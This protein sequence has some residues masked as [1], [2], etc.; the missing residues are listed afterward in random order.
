MSEEATTGEQKKILIVDDEQ[1]LR[2]AIEVTLSGLGHQVFTAENGIE[3]VEIALTEH[4][5][6]MLL[7]L[8]MPKMDGHAVLKRLRRDEAWGKK[9]NI[10]VLTALNDLETLSQTLEEGGLEYIVKSDV[11]LEDIAKKITEKLA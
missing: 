10:I 8:N 7:D 3:A 11:S 6:V 9:A 1:D 5:D 4:P 2:E